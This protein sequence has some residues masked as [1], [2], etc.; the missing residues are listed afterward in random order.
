MGQGLRSPGEPG[1]DAPSIILPQL[2]LKNPYKNLKR[3]RLEKK[4]TCF[5]FC[6]ASFRFLKLL[7]KLF[8]FAADPDDDRIVSHDALRFMLYYHC[9][10]DTS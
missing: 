5:V 7:F 6:F 3:K 1:G 10:R 4:L 9:V 8:C 2:P